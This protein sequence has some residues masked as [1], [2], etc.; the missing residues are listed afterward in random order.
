MFPGRTDRVVLDGVIDPAR[1]SARLW[2][3]VEG[4]DRQALRGWASWAAARDGAYGLGGTRG[5]VLATVE[6]IRVAAARTPLRLGGHRL[7]AHVMPV[8]A[9]NGLSQHNDT[10]YEDF[11]PGVQDMLRASRGQRVTPSPWL[12]GVLEFV[13]TGTDSPYGSAQA[14]IVCGDN[15]APRDPE[16]YWR[17][18]QRT[19]AQDPLFVPVTNN[20]NPCVFWDRPRERPT[21]IRD[22]LP[23][24]LVNATGDPRT[25]YDGA[26]T[27]RAM[28]PSSRLVTLK[29]SDQHA[30]YGVYGSACV[31]DA[32]NAYLATGRVPARDL[33]CATRAG[34]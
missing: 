32:V 11:A 24:L 9:L 17:D 23:A 30:L 5:E 8:V 26:T 27:V 21:R 12:A 13:L 31:D 4:A 6:R 16:V 10:A 3:G 28:W 19:R 15:A 33:D 18:V 7:D 34:G 14:A 22:D 20:L 25:S 2:R 29:G 1:Y